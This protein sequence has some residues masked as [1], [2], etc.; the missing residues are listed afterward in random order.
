MFAS[1]NE[2]DPQDETAEDEE[3]QD[4]LPPVNQGEPAQIRGTDI[5]SKMTRPA[6]HFTEA[7]LL[8]AM[9]N[10]ARFVEEEQFKRILKETAG[11]GTPATRAAT[12]EGAVQRGYVQRKKKILVATDKAHALIAVLPAAIKSPGLTAAWEQQLEAIADGTGDMNG[13]MRQITGWISETVEQLKEAAPALTVQGGELEAAFRS[14]KP[15]EHECFTCGGLLRRVKGKNGFFWGCQN[16]ACRKTFPD[17]KGKPETRP[18][19]NN[20]LAPKCPDCN[21]AM[22]LRKGKA[23]GKKRATDFWG[24]TAYP[25]CKGIVAYSKKV[26]G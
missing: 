1:D 18:D 25:Q 10:I 22:R 23:P 19:A 15:P 16:Q 11:L 17:N 12:I 24:C 13:F 5:Q 2:S 26:H 4:K 7:S 9:E 3:E 20:P 6:P 8:S 21:S 14:A